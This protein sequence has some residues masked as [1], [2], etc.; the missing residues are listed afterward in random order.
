MDISV[1]VYVML[2]LSLHYSTSAMSHAFRSRIEIESNNLC[3]IGSWILFAFVLNSS[4]IN[5]PK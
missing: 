2:I 5:K 3:L 4:K 1:F